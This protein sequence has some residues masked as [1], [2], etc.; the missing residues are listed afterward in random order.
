M[1]SGYIYR[2]RHRR[3]STSLPAMNC[4]EYLLPYICINIHDIAAL[5]QYRNKF[6]GINNAFFD[7]VPPY[8][9]FSA[10][11]FS[12]AHINFGLYVDF[13]F[14]VPQR[15]CNIIFNTFFTHHFFTHFIIIKLI[16]C[17]GFS[18]NFLQC[19]ISIVTHQADVHVIL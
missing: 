16:N 1:A 12:T 14:F 19:H 6:I 10:N 4:C 17:I 13:K 3:N 7:A 9:C 15:H 11:Y 5:F 18:F 8:K 2:N